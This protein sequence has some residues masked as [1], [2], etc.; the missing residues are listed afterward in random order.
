MLAAWL[1]LGSAALA[2]G[3]EQVAPAPVAPPALP[4]VRQATKRLTV[5]AR[6]D[7]DADVVGIVAAGEPFLVLLRVPGPGCPDEGW[8]LL[9][10][11]YACLAR[12]LTAAAGLAPVVLP[13]L[14]AFD[15]PSPSE[16]RQY[17]RT[18]TWARDPG[19]TEALLPF[20][21]GKA[22]RGWSGA[23]YTDQAAW[24]RGDPPLESPPDEADEGRKAHFVAAIETP[25]GAALVKEDGKLTPLADE[26]VYPVSR[27]QG[28]ELT[29]SGALGL[30]EVQAWVRA[31]G[32]ANVRDSRQ[33]GG[34]V[35]AV[36]PFQSALRLRPTED[37]AWFSI[38]A[39]PSV[40]GF[41]AA[42]VVRWT[43]PLPA[44]E[45]V[46]AG[47]VWLDVDVSQ[48]VLLLM[49]GNAVLFA[50]LVSTGL[51]TKD[52]PPG[53]YTMLDKTIYGDMDSKPDADEPYHVE[54]VP[55]VM[56]FRPRYAVHGVFWHWGF[57]N[58][59]SH[60]CVNLS[61]LDAHRVF[62]AVLPRLPGGWSSATATAESPGTVVRI[63]EKDA[64][65]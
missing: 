20:V 5:R 47:A 50:T 7:G 53:V 33:P 44:P 60:G 35:T 4:E 65:P 22:W 59:A 49:Q 31:Y 21:Y 58:P 18:G 12:T 14:V 26:F 57:G 8:G 30:G 23:T 19:A 13:R 25:R 43:R 11:G 41:V 24:E 16:Y 52:T 42:L 40:G 9:D 54:D 56:H 27:F 1:L 45:Q 38:A 39:G 63:R 6:P 64:A 62:D 36:L 17:V 55:W 48:Q 32:G 34:Q 10:G 29:G 37:P 3:L 46:P 28:V 15:S 51:A 2:E 61:P